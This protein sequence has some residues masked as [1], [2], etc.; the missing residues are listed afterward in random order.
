MA[1][2][3]LRLIGINTGLWYD[4]VVTLVESVR[5]PLTTILTEFPGNNQHPLFSVLGHLSVSLFGEHPWSLRLPAALLGAATVPVLY[6]F[7]R[8][9]ASRREALA[10]CVLLTTAYHHVWFSQNARGYSA[11]ALLTTLSSWMLLRLLRRE[12]RGDAV[13]YAL[14]AG[15]GVYAHLT[16]VFLV[17]SQALVCAAAAIARP[18]LRRRWRLPFSAFALSGVLAFA[19]Y[20]PVLLDLKQF[21]VDKAVIPGVATPRWALLELLR[22]LQIGFGAAAAALAAGALVVAGLWSYFRQSP[23][24]LALFLAPGVVTVGSTLALGR[25]V[26]PRF[27]F[28]LV[29]FALLIVV[30]GALAATALVPAARR[31]IAGSLVIGVIALASL[32]ALW[33]NYRFPKQDFEGARRFA[34]QRRGPG[35]VIATT[36]LAAYVYLNYHNRDWPELMNVDDLRRAQS[37]GRRV[38]VV[39]TLPRYLAIMVPDVNAVLEKECPTAAEFRG[40]VGGG[41]VVVCAI[42]PGDGRP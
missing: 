36:G 14:A 28:F 10:A 25:P 35:D 32:V 4:E 17:A 3:V 27:L 11:V 34:E 21:F 12:G 9:F 39:Y 37:G 33:P 23:F 24:V 18:D 22:G 7:A 31:E 26:Y 5:Q 16:M 8:E 42:Q 38:W 15:L 40:T 19:L 20:A 2:L 29:A 13:A 41:Q 6:G 30:R 1:A